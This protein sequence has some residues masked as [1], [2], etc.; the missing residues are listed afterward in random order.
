MRGYSLKQLKE[1]PIWSSLVNILCHRTYFSRLW[2]VQEIA[3]F[4]LDDTLI[5]CGSNSLPWRKYRDVA[6]LLQYCNLLAESLASM[7]VINLANI[8]FL[9]DL[10]RQ[11]Q[12]CK[13]ML[14]DCI[15]ATHNCAVS[16]R[17]DRVFALLGMVD[18][19]T[20]S[21]LQKVDYSS[22]LGNIFLEATECLIKDSKSLDYLYD[23]ETSVIDRTQEPN[24]P[25]WVSWMDFNPLMKIPTI[26][27]GSGGVFVPETPVTIH[28][29]VLKVSGFAFDVVVNVYDNLSKANFK[30]QILKI[31]DELAQSPSTSRYPH[32]A[33]NVLWRILTLMDESPGTGDHLDFVAFIAQLNLERMGFTEG[34]LAQ[35]PKLSILAQDNPSIRSRF[36]EALAAD[37]DVEMLCNTDVE[38]AKW[39]KQA[40]EGGGHTFKNY[41][42]DIC[43]GQ[44]FKSGVCEGRNVFSSA[45]GYCGVGPFGTTTQKTPLQQS[46]WEI[47]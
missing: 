2:I 20:R 37:F 14:D 29:S 16:D 47:A 31:H 45:K 42:V 1:D 3:L 4:S 7:H 11:V 6:M 26:F 9:G 27:G 35:N 38:M 8:R 21:Q 33:I 18:D 34:I 10:Q 13:A 24:I 5:C 23:Y 39:T 41:L 40:S 36:T 44:M 25:S 15:I 30:S 17:R 32:F 46:K 19:I 43:E 28:D 22:S 12:K